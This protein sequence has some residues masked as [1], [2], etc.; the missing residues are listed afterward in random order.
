MNKITSNWD[1][2]KFTLTLNLMVVQ[3]IVL[4]ILY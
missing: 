2:M 4:M 1:I 3:I